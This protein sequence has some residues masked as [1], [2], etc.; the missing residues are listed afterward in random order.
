MGYTFFC[1]S[2]SKCDF[3][4]FFTFLDNWPRATLARGCV[5]ANA[6]HNSAAGL[7]FEP[8][9]SRALWGPVKFSFVGLESWELYI[10]KC[11]NQSVDHAVQYPCGRNWL[12]LHL[13]SLWMV[14]RHLLPAASYSSLYFHSTR[15]SR[16]KTGN[17]SHRTI[18]SQFTNDTL[19]ALNSC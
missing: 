8:R 5:T 3:Y 13:L 17:L 11:S 6:A 18:S 12:L 10:L 19:W 7:F 2:I 1:L 9:Y 15:E 4:F 14:W 16:V